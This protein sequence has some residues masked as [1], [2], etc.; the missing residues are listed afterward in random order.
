[1]MKFHAL[2]L[3]PVFAF[4][5]AAPAS[6]QAVVDNPGLCAQFYPDANCDNYGPGN[7][8]NGRYS[9]RGFPAANA[10][11]AAPAWHASLK[12]HHVH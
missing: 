1:M 10:F 7:P 11:M 6:A 5:F 3:A 8:Y 2:L 9:S 4:A 12:K